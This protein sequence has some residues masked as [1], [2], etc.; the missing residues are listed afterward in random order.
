MSAG[1]GSVKNQFT[2]THKL[3]VSPKKFTVGNVYAHWCTPAWKMHMGEHASKN[4]TLAVCIMTEG[5]YPSRQGT[6]KVIFTGLLSKKQEIKDET[7]ALK[8]TLLDGQDVSKLWDMQT[9]SQLSTPPPPI[10]FKVGSTPS[11]DQDLSWDQE[12]DTQS[13]EPPRYPPP[14][15]RCQFL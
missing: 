5:W 7:R 2:D 11:V 6:G 14:P 8:P 3:L 9:F 4:N 15:L 13:T 10:F 1:L 12:S